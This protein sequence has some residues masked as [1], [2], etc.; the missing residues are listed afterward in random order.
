MRNIGKIARVWIMWAGVCFASMAT[1]APS[2]GHWKMVDRQE[3]EGAWTWSKRQ[4]IPGYGLT[5]SADFDGD[6]K[7][8]RADLVENS[9]KDEAGIQIWLSEKNQ[10]TVMPIGKESL[11]ADYILQAASP[12]AFGV[13]CRSDYLAGDCP[14]PV[15]IGNSSII[16][17]R[18]NAGQEIIYYD[19]DAMTSDELE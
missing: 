13:S 2:A 7:P 17:D 15:D 6:G 1:A 18:M 16:L 19:G 3:L 9:A 10:T 8:D 4:P 5:V 14:E 12:G 11:V